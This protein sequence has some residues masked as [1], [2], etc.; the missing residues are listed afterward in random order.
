MKLRQFVTYTILFLLAPLAFSEVFFSGYAGMKGDIYSDPGAEEG[1]FDPMLQIQ[2]YFAGQLNLSKSF[3]VR[4]EFSLQ[5]EDIFASG[6]FNDTQALFCI[7][8]L[9]ATYIKPFLGN[10]Q[11]IS[12]FFGTFEPIG[13]D[14]FLQRQ[15]G[16]KPL[17]SLITES[18]LGLKGS[19][20]YPFYGAGA[21]YVVH[22]D[23]APVASGLYI[24]KNHASNDD[25]DDQLN[26]DWRFA[27]V[28]SLFTLDFATGL[29]APLSKKYEDNDVILLIDTLYLHSG[30]EL[31]IGDRYGQSL[32][33]QAGFEQ[34]PL[35]SNSE[36]NKL[37]DSDTYLLVESRL[38]AT[39]CKFHLTFFNFPD[40]LLEES[41]VPEIP[42]KKLIFVEDSLG[43]NIALFTDN[44]SVNNK[45]IQFGF[46]TTFSLP[47]KHLFDLKV[48]S[49]AELKELLGTEDDDTENDYNVKVSPFLTVPVMSGTLHLMFQANITDIK[50]NGWEQAVK[51]N[52]G[53]KAQI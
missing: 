49:L 47:G 5:S 41:S 45:N 20:I 12:G 37:K 6:V 16:I 43:L 4:G 32:F 1:E 39:D 13:S 22:F 26:F 17:T 23:K 8:E 11:Y 7:N 25:E 27:T 9:S 44:L 18:W 31:F 24:Y 35:K 38:T 53:Y 48:K 34:V 36:E 28:N 2:S 15:F 19:Y 46:H 14:I 29:G 52:I 50:D 10:T 40:S 3:L 21:S 51:L 33:M 30:M 42:N